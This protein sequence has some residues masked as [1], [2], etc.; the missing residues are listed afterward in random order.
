MLDE[1]ETQRL[2]VRRADFPRFTQNRH[3]QHD[4]RWNPRKS[5]YADFRAQ[6]TQ[7]LRSLQRRE[8]DLEDAARKLDQRQK[9]TEKLRIQRDTAS[10][11]HDRIKIQ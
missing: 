11:D 4:S 2:K 9:E 10:A 3:P 5:C 7:C 8:R 1:V 6:D